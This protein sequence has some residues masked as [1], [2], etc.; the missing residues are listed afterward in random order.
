[1]HELSAQVEQDINSAASLYD[2]M[3]RCVDLY[4]C[5]AGCALTCRAH[6]PPSLRLSALPSKLETL[7]VTGDGASGTRDHSTLLRTLLG[8]DGDGTRAVTQAVSSCAQAPHTHFGG[9]EF[10]Q[11]RAVR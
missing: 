3:R 10:E 5:A 9:S 7:L 6:Q 8:C 4:L 11:V 2:A 1:M